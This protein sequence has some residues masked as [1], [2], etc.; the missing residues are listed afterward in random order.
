MTQEGVMSLTLRLDR[1]IMGAAFAFM[2]LI[3]LGAF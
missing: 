2:M 3:V 1:L